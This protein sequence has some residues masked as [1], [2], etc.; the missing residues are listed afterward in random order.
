MSITRHN[1][2][3][4]IDWGVKT[5]GW[6]FVKLGELDP[7]EVYP[8]KGCFITK[9]NGFGEG[10]VIISDGYLVSIPGRYLDTVR[11]IM[12]TTEDIADIKAG[13]VGFKYSEFKSKKHNRTGYD[14]EF[15]DL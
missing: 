11:D 14:V 12:G 13:K 2:H 9:D 5:D 8:V 7:G 6:D 1:K 4:S 3:K 10:V 15:V